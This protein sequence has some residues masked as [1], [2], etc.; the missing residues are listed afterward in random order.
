MV[1]RFYVTLKN[2]LCIFSR[3]ITMKM[4]YDYKDISSLQKNF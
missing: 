2:T 3:F 1:N 4:Y